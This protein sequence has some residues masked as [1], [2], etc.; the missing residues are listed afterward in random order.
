MAQRRLVVLMGGLLGCG[1]RIRRK[2]VGME[3]DY[4]EGLSGLFLYLILAKVFLTR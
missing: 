2:Y 1:K 4:D 3:R